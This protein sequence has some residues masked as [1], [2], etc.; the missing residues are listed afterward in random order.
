[1]VSDAGLL[2]LSGAFRLLL[3][4]AK[5]RLSGLAHKRSFGSEEDRH[6]FALPLTSIN[7]KGW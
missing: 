2:M 6:I 1:L 4:P 3:T 5:M 7:R